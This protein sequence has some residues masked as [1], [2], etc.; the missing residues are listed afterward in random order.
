MWDIVLIV[1]FSIAGLC[2]L[3]LLIKLLIKVPKNLLI[4]DTY[5]GLFWWSIFWIICIPF[6][7]HS[8]FSRRR[9][10][11]TREAIAWNIFLNVEFYRQ[12]QMLQNIPIGMTLKEYEKLHPK[13]KWI[14][15]GKNPQEIYDILTKY[16]IGTEPKKNK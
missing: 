16:G 5:S 1:Y 9:Y 15:E 12:T 7:I 14:I 8:D 10:N 11:K 2:M 6:T 13:M 4:G 3:A